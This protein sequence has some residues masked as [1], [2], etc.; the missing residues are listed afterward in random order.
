MERALRRYSTQIHDY[1][2]S[3]FNGRLVLFVMKATDE[4]MSSASTCAESQRS[5]KY[6]WLSASMNKYDLS[7]NNGMGEVNQREHNNL[8]N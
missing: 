5:H 7:V 4:V 1:G 8:C 6:E 3:G 2:L